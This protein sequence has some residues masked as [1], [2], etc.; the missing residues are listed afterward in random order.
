MEHCLILCA[1]DEMM[2]QAHDRKAKSWVLDG[3]YPLQKKGQG[4]RLHQSNMI[5][6]TVGWMKEASQTM[7]YEK[8]YNGY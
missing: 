1:H 2:V 8:N 3:E 5:C 7:E 6:S 4:Q